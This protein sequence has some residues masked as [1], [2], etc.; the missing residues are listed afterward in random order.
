MININKLVK[1]GVDAAT[2]NAPAL[3]TAFG[4]VGV[5][6][7]ALLTGKASFQA[8]KKIADAESVANMKRT[9]GEERVVL[10]KEE[11]FRLVWTLYIAPVST[12]VLTCGA[13]VM[14]HRVSSRRAAVLAAAYALNEGKLEEYQE[15]VKEKFG[16]KKEQD[17]R[18][19]VA[20][21]RVDRDYKEGTVI[22]DPMEGKV[23]VR[24]DYSGRFFWSSVE[25]VNRAVNEINREINLNVSGYQTVSDFY[26]ILDLEHV[27]VS[28][29]FGW[30]TECPLEL[31]WSTTTTPDQK[32]AVHSFEFVN[33][34]IMNPGSRDSFR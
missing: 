8:A 12:G 34:P 15:K 18:D 24:D 22:F 26:D 33:T 11:K 29:Y 3:L 20:Q 28:D 32:H 14:A 2:N 13:V 7:T 10:S 30:N 16:V 9:A 21:D 1:S 4:T 31:T 17:V 6:T 5:V 23:L 19:S 25:D 27:S